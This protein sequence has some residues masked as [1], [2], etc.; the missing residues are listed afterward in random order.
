MYRKIAV[1]GG[2]Y[3]NIPAL[4]A[5]MADAKKAGCDGFFFLGDAIGFAG[6][7]DEILEIIFR[8]FDTFLAGNLETE[9]AEGNNDCNCGYAAA[10]DEITGCKAFDW[11][12]KSLSERYKR[13]LKGLP[14]EIVIRTSLGNILLCHG[15][16]DVQNEFLYESTVNEESLQDWIKKYNVQG[17]ICTHTGLPWI[18]LIGNREFAMNC[19]STGKPDHDGDPAIHYGI[20]ETA[21]SFRLSIRRVNYDFLSFAEQL[22]KE[23]VD[24]I[25]ITPLRTGI[26]TC[27]VKSL[28]EKEQKDCVIKQGN[29]FYESNTEPK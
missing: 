11:A 4:K 20:V 25:F 7:S 29:H 27:G 24:D 23:G 12:L 1:M 14:N 18:K 8:E 16:P 13:K 6:H 17:I 10:E 2:A 5:C 3:G 21:D 9:A 15:S 28:P 19:G 22:E 26:W